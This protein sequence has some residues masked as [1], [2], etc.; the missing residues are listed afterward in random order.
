MYVGKKIQSFQVAEILRKSSDFLS[1]VKR[2]F[3]KKWK[4]RAKHQSLSPSNTP[5]SDRASVARS[6]A[7]ESLVIF[8]LNNLKILTNFN[9]NQKFW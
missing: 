2:P 7:G 9:F 1:T 3:K 4:N 6:S 8:F 5:L